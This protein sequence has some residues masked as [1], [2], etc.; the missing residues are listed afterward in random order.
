MRIDI[1]RWCLDP[2]HTILRV[3]TQVRLGDAKHI[4]G[5]YHSHSETELELI[6]NSRRQ[7]RKIPRNSIV[8]CIPVTIA[9]VC[10]ELTL[11]LEFAR[12]VQ[13]GIKN[14]RC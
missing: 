7:I 2:G 1:E 12:N 6:C 8:A 11:L 4:Y 5:V 9:E 3:I 13:D 14:I 10:G